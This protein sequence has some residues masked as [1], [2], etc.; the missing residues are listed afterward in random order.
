MCHMSNRATLRDLHLK[1]SEIVG[2]VAGGEAFLIEKRGVPVAELRPLTGHL[3]TR[4][5]PDREKVLK[6]LPRVKLD[7]GRILEQDRS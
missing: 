4:R 5:L 1:T 7:S 3:P 2:R 6:R